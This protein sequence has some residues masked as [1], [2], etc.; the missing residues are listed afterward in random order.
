MDKPALLKKLETVLDEWARS[1]T[2]GVIE[3]DVRDGVPTLFRR[4]LQEKL[5]EEHPRG[6]ETYR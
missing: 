2:W 1:R 3:I 6:R 4:S 5:T